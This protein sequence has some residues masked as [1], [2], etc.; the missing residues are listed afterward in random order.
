MELELEEEGKIR[1][2]ALLDWEMSWSTSREGE[3][4]SINPPL[5]KEASALTTTQSLLAKI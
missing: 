5:P 4:Q 1:S 3:N 2:N